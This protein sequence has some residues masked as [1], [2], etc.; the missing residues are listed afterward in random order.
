MPEFIH[1]HNHT[2]YSLLD[3]ACT[4]GALVQAAVE[5]KMSAV[6]LTDHG[7]LLGRDPVL[8]EGEEGWH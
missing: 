6:A 4:V 7:V 8:Q 5:N 3:G 1:L 2:D